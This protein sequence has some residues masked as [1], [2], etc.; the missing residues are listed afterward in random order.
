MKATT[1]SA[2]VVIAIANQKGGTGKSTTAAA[3]A[4][5]LTAKRIKTLLID[6]DGQGNTTDT[7]AIDPTGATIYDVLT[8]AAPVAKAI[9]A[10][11][12]HGDIIPAAPE[13]A[14]MDSV[15]TATGKEHRLK[16]VLSTIQGRYDYIIIDTP[17]A[18]GVLTVNALTAATGIVI[19]SAADKYG[20]GGI[21]QLR[22]TIDA[23]REYTNPNLKIY[24]I[25]LT[26]HSTRRILLR[27][28]AEGIAKLAKDMKTKVFKTFIRE[29]TAIREAQSKRRSIFEYAPQST[30]VEDYKNFIAE[31][32]KTV[33][34]T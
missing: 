24:G 2:T 33:G 10:T 22:G 14:G 31:I 13:L 12:G 26:R 21:K 32:I 3:M 27:D 18:L 16:K 15:L 29:C 17:P 5:G 28:Y 6:M 11:A 20:Y 30:G 4:A 19:P 25:L 9:Q 1:K 34:R 7:A 23:I 8:N